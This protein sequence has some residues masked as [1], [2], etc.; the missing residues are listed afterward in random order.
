MTLRDDGKL[1]DILPGFGRDRQQAE[2][3]TKFLGFEP[4]SNPEDELV[5]TIGTQRGHTGRGAG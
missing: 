3:L 1:V 5:A 2:G 4:A